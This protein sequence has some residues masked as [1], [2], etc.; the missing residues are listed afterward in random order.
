MG[1]SRT[2][3]KRH[4]KACGQPARG[5]DGPMG[6][7]KCKNFIGAEE[8]APIFNNLGGELSDSDSDCDL[9]NFLIDDMGEAESHMNYRDILDADNSHARGGSSPQ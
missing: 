6:V 8:R 9:A 5:H 3:D 1:R 4:C 2:S 7:N